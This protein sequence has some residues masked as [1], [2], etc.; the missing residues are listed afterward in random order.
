V[1]EAL[2]RFFFFVGIRPQLGHFVTQRVVATRILPTDGVGNEVDHCRR[3]WRNDAVEDRIIG[4]LIWREWKRI[5]NGH[6][7]IIAA[8]ELA[9]RADAT[10]IAFA[11]QEMESARATA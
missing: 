6:V 3:S 8:S 11:K 2:V 1:L 7:W 4:T 9:L 5:P 10:P